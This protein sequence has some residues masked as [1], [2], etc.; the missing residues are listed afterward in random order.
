MECVTSAVPVADPR[1][2]EIT[3]DL[4]FRPSPS[5][6]HPSDHVAPPS[7]Y[8]EVADAHTWP[9]ACPCGWEPSELTDI[10]TLQQALQN[11]AMAEDDYQLATAPVLG[12]A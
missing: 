9:H 4:R 6:I 1:L 3:E 10:A 11:E 7:V 2:K 12:H 5:P 8:R